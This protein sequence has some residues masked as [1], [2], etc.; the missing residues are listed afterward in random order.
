MKA[1]PVTG[2][3]GWVVA[4]VPDVECCVFAVVV[5]TGTTI[6]RAPFV[7]T[8]GI[9]FTPTVSNLVTTAVIVVKPTA[10][11]LSTLDWLEGCVKGKMIGTFGM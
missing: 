5:I 4:A 7:M 10:A 6:V 8:T 11:I 3:N 2:S 9:P 1:G